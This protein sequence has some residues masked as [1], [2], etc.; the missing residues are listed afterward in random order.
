[1]ECSWPEYGAARRSGG[2]W[3]DPG[4]VP[5]GHP[6]QPSSDSV[7][8]ERGALL[9]AD[10]DAALE[11]LVVGT[12]FAAGK[13]FTHGLDDQAFLRHAGLLEFAGHHLRAFLRQALVELV[14][15][16]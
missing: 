8:G 2:G 9:Q 11:R 16:T 5:P 6:C 13:S 1:M 3:H 7:A 12:G 14:V 15:T 4:V 10:L